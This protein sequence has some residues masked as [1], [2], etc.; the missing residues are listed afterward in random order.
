MTVAGAWQPMR[1]RRPVRA[2]GGDVTRGQAEDAARV[3]RELVGQVA[4]LYSEEPARRA[5]AIDAGEDNG[6]WFVRVVCREC[7]PRL[8]RGIP[9]A[10]DDI[11]VRIFAEGPDVRTQGG[12]SSVRTGEFL[13]QKTIADLRDFMRVVIYEQN[14]LSSASQ[15]CTAWAEK[16]A[17]AAADWRK[18][19]DEY[20]QKLANLIAQAQNRVDSWAEWTWP[21][22]PAGTAGPNCI[23]CGEGD[24]YKD[25]VAIRK[26]AAHLDAE[27]RASSNCT[28]PDYSGMPQPTAGDPDLKVYNATGVVTNAVDSTI[29]SAKDLV[30]SRTPYLVIGAM[31]GVF[32]LLWVQRRSP[33]TA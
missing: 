32:V 31:A 19:F 27:L 13:G 26:V 25:L 2:G 6:L 7:P 15:A 16:D 29:A 4:L 30:K 8:R 12:A 18:R 1:P 17:A 20:A 33:S 14:Q 3:V 23:N 5:I 11:E 9:R 24:I 10:V 28:P 21:Y 22:A